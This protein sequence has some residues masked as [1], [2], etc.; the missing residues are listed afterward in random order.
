MYPPKMALRYPLLLLKNSNLEKELRLISK[1]DHWS[2]TRPIFRCIINF[3]VEKELECKK[4]A[5]KGL[6]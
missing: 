5:A 2:L 4:I 1:C 3:Q 6:P